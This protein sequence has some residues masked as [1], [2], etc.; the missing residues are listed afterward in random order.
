MRGV[1]AQR[2]DDLLARRCEAALGQVVAEQV[3][4]RDQR[5][6]LERQQPGGTREVVAVGLGIDVDLLALDLG[7][8][9]VAAAAEVDDVQHVEVL[10]QLLVGDLQ[11]LAHVGDPRPRRLAG[12]PD[13]IRMPAS[14]TR[15][16]KRS[17][18]IG[19]LALA[20]VGPGRPGGRSP[21]RSSPR[22][23]V[24]GSATKSELLVGVALEDRG[25]ALGGLV[26]ELGRIEQARVLAQPQHPRHELARL[27][28]LGRE[29]DAGA[30][31]AARPGPPLAAGLRHGG[32]VAVLAEV[33]LDEP[34]DAL[35]DP[36]LRACRRARPAASRRGARRPT[37]RSRRAS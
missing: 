19:G 6:R 28:E 4:R 2:G 9:H 32:E 37:G 22:R 3:D 25:E 5:L 23:R 20:V 24:A 1:V 27:R 13:W 16:A 7:V 14:A 35:R 15:R 31:H 18:R 11:A 12:A 10:A 17:G 21:K 34:R 36:D 26:D 33:A 8:Q 30:G 29:D